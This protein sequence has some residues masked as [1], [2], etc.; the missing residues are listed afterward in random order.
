[1]SPEVEFDPDHV[2]TAWEAAWVARTGTVP[3]LQR[4]PQASPP[5]TGARRQP[6]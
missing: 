1:M 4:S 5:A 6:D 3:S 2:L